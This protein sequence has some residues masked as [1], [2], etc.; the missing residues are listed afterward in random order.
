MFS[1][2]VNK[3]YNKSTFRSS[4]FE[5]NFPMHKNVNHNFISQNKPIAKTDLRTFLQSDKVSFNNRSQNN[6]LLNASV[7]VGTAGTLTVAQ[8]FVKKLSEVCAHLLMAGKEFTS[9]ENVK[10][11][12]TAMKEKNG[13]KANIHF[14]DN[15]NKHLLKDK[16]PMLANSL[17][18]VANGR[19]AFYAH[20]KDIAVAP[21][22]RPSLILHELGHAI[23]NEKSKLFKGLQKCRIIGYNAPAILLLANHFFSKPKN[24]GEETFLEKHAG[25]IG[26]AAFLPTIIEEGAASIRGI[27][28]AKQT[29]GKNV[30]LGALKRNYFFAWMTYLLAGIG[31]GIASKLAVSG[32]NETKEDNSQQTILNPLI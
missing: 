29:L 5:Q 18:T 20:M 15:A 28:A 25:K 26:F 11:V 2:T 32:R 6:E 24:D 13:L 17:D 3:N 31:M 19:N 22:S 16:F 12:A 23:N 30:N 27:N 8:W 4:I 1:A 7:A 14:I 21:K 9:G 10:K